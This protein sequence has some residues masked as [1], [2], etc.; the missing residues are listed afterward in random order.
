M[1]P[2]TR[3]SSISGS[4]LCHLL[5][6]LT[7]L[8]TAA[9]LCGVAL[10]E[11]K[12]PSPSPWKAQERIGRVVVGEFGGGYS[13]GPAKF[14]NVG[15]YVN[16]DW[17]I[18]GFQEESRT[19]FFGESTSRGLR[20]KNFLNSALYTKVGLVH[21]TISGRNMFLD[22]A[23]STFSGTNT[24]YEIKYWDFGPEVTF[25]HQ[26]QWITFH[27]GVDLAGVYWPLYASVADVT[28][29]ED[30]TVTTKKAQ[31]DIKPEPAARLLRVYFGFSL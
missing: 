2:T 3:R 11:E 26:W 29:T 27:M 1:K 6:V 18:E 10:A 30:G 28:K 22:M 19:W 7:F 21:R 20:S 24:H 31:D 25:G 15:F 4:A 9:S 23:S 16:P 12:K 13:S 8:L 14:A 17:V 5:S